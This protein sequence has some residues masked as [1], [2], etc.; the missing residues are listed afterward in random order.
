MTNLL[1]VEQTTK[2]ESSS[3]MKI[4]TTVTHTDNVELEIELPYFC[5]DEG[6]GKFYMLESDKKIVTVDPSNIYTA[7][8]SCSSP[9]I[10]SSEIAKSVIITE[11]EFRDALLAAFTNITSSKKAAA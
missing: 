6:T 10:Y 8:V 1:S 2:L 7:I 4:T 5:K 11:D 3:T 9:S